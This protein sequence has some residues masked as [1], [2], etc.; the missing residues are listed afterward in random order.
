M[1][2]RED[3]FK[4]KFQIFAKKEKKIKV[5]TLLNFLIINPFAIKNHNLTRLIR[6]IYNSNN[7]FTTG[8]TILSATAELSELQ[9]ES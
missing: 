6:I 4:W 9:K 8:L 2:G 1:M 5:E 3:S 7:R